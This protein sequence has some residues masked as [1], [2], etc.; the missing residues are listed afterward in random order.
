MC[1]TVKELLGILES[2]SG[3]G[4]ATEEKTQGYDEDT[5]SFEDYAE[6]RKTLIQQ[7]VYDKNTH[8]NEIL[9]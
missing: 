2:M 5:M 3:E 7:D 6:L 8:L 9:Y 1:T 4:E